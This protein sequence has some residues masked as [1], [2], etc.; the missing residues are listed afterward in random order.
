MKRTFVMTRTKI[1]AFWAAA[2]LVA[3]IAVSFG[4]MSGEAETALYLGLVAAAVASISQS[5]CG[6]C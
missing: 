1:A 6:S 2:I 5:R 3:A 4:T